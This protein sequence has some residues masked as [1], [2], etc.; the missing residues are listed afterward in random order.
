MKISKKIIAKLCLVLSLSIFPAIALAE[1]FVVRNIK[2]NGLQRVSKGT[3]LNYL[4]VQPGEEIDASDTANIIRSLYDTGFFQSVSLEREGDVLVVNIVERAT[5]GSV[6]VHGNKDI[7]TDK[8]KDFLKQIGLVKGRVFQKSSLE[9]LEKDL[10][11]TYTARGKYNARIESEVIDL[12][13][14]RVGI[15]INISEGRVSRIKSIRITGYRD[16][17]HR[18]LLGEFSLSSSTVYTY[19]NKKDQYTKAAMDASLEALRSFYLDRGYLKFAIVS[20]QVQL[21]PDKKDVFIHVQIEEGPQYRFEGYAISGNTIISR[22]KLAALIDIRKGTVFSRKRVTES[23][24]AIGMALGDEGY[25]FPVI[26][27]EPRIDET[28]KTVF[29]TFVIDPGR[30]VYVRHINFHG[31]TRTA[32]YVLRNVIRQNEGSLLSLHNIKESERQLRVLGYLK[33]VDVKTSPVTGANNQVDLDITV[34]EAPTAEASVSLGYGTNRLQFNAAVNHR[35]FMG[36]GKTVGLDFNASAFGQSY[37][38]NYY[39]PFYTQTGIGRGISGYFQYVTPGKVDI[40]RYTANRFGLDVGYN[41]LLSE[42]S[43]FSFGYGFQG[44]DIRSVGD[45]RQIYRFIE[46]NGKQYQQV[47]LSAGWNRNTYDQVPYPTRGINQQ[48]NAFIALPMNHHSLTYYKGGYQARWYQPVYSGFIFSLTGN[49]GYGNSFAKKPGLPFFEN[50]YAGGITQPGQ[51][52]GYDTN[53]LGPQDSNGNSLG[54]N[55]LANAS[56]ALILPYPLSWETVRTSLFADAGNVFA[57]S[58]P[59]VYRGSQSGPLRYS[60]GISLEWRSPFGPLAFS[61]AQP[62]NKQP[63]DQIE[64]FQFTL[65]GVF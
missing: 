62:L 58:I 53:S 32:D 45:V 16:F 18:E 65:A 21:S 52:R 39:N 41:V 64:N 29:I 40:S 61:L 60:A 20:S 30:R 31:N 6:T 37:S 9:R 14:N 12:T 27:A 2:I 11:Q 46:D 57:E 8:M 50:Y 5:I 59:L 33:N 22:E 4:S 49:V 43:S 47:R 55:F 7:P 15:T 1:S 44:M 63:G 34:E 26:N 56:A 28:T 23:I 38:F 13:D 36:T 48:L 3:V 19:F 10:K 54:G 51:V 17:T 25:G 35:N 24:S 42:Y